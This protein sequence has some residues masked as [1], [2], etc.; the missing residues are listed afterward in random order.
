[1]RVLGAVGLGVLVAFCVLNAPIYA[2]TILVTDPAGLGAS[3][4][5]DWAQLGFDQA[6]IPQNFSASIP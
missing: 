4:T 2:V 6:S 3:D 5:V 1:M